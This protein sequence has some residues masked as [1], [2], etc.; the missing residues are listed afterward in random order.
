MTILD[1]L[2]PADLDKI[3]KKVQDALLKQAGRNRH[4]IGLPARRTLPEEI[5]T[6]DSSDLSCCGLEMKYQ[7]IF[8]VREY[9]CQH[10]Y[11]HPRIW[12]NQDNGDMIREEE[13]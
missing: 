1:D 12:V 7:D 10:R 9:F 13:L 3:V 6:S 8:N 4:T 5:V 2:S 11:H